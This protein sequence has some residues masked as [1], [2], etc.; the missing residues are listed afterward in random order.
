MQLLMVIWK[1]Y[2]G[3]VRMDVIGMI[4]TVFC[5]GLQWSFGSVKMGSF[6]WM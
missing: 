1:F 2:N 3:P 6:E 4:K 5:C